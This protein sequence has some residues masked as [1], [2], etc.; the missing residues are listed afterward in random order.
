MTQLDYSAFFLDQLLLG[1]AALPGMFW[2]A[3]QQDPWLWSLPALVVV[4]IAL[5]AAPAKPRR[6]RRY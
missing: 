3:A 6:R 2:T 5:K 1:F 4:S